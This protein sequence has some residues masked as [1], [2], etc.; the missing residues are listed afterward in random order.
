MC[1]CVRVCVFLSLLFVFTV[2]IYGIPDS[3]LRSSKKLSLRYCSKSSSSL[4]IFMEPRIFELQSLQYIVT[5][6]RL[7]NT[8]AFNAFCVFESFF[9]TLLIITFI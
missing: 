1:V 7:H 2:A 3:V 8:F 9:I 5:V 6:I 4:I